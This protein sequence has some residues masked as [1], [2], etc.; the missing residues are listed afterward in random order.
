MLFNKYQYNQFGIN[1]RGY[2]QSSLAINEEGK[3]FWVKWILGIEKNDTKAKILADKLRHLQKARHSALPEIIEYGYDQE[4]NAFAIVYEYLEEVETLENKVHEIN[5]QNAISGLIDISDCLKELHFRYRI[6]HGDIHPANILVDKN[7]QFYLVDFGLSD[8][9]KTFSQTKDLEIFARSFAAPEK[10]NKLV[11][12][13]PFQADIFSIGKVVEWFFDERQEQLAEEEYRDL[14][15]LLAEN[16]SDRPNWEQVID[17]LKKIATASETEAVQVDFHSSN[18]YEI[19]YELKSSNPIFDIS[20]KEGANYLLDIIIGN[21]L[22]EGVIWIK[23]ERKLLFN[24]I[25]PL[26]SLDS[27]IIDRKIKDGKKLP[28]KFVYTDKY[29]HNRADLTPYFQKCF[30]QKKTRNQVKKKQTCCKRRTKFLS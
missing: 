12:G 18:R 3:E 24:S 10:L 2:S 1:K 27:K 15:K 26:N 9:A 25:K 11:K 29:T 28:F 7:G 4:Q 21:W 6:N 20:P 22:C 8:L 14:Q 13:F 17:I 30:E 19:L 23:S 16:P 5:T